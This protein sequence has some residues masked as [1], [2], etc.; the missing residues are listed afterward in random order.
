LR[1]KATPGRFLIYFDEFSA[2]LTE[3]TRAT[4]ADVARRAREGKAVAVRIEA[5]ASATGSQLA[6]RYLAMTRSQV[7]ADELV[8]DGLDA[9]MLRQVAI[10]QSGS[11][12]P[13]VAERR[14]DLVIER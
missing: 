8:K 9:G 7:V 5:R 4:L 12:D 1:S 14:V 10:G 2:N 3:Q 13:S 11:E 6:N